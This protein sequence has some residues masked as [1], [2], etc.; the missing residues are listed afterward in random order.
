MTLI[1]LVIAVGAAITWQPAVDIATG[2]G[3]KG[4][5]QQNNSRFDY[6]DDP[7]VV[8]LPG[9]A[10]AVAWVDQRDKDIHLQ[11]FERTGAPRLPHAVNVSRTPAI[12]SWLPRLAIA[13]DHPRAIYVLWQEIVFS[14]G[15]HGGEIL[16]ARSLDGGA[17]FSAPLNLSRSQA[18]DGKARLST[19]AWHNGSLD[20]AVAPDRTLHAAW[21]DYEGALWFASSSD[22]G[23]SFTSPTQIAGTHDLPARAPSLAVDA[24]NT[25]YLAWTI[26]ETDHADVHVASRI[27]GGRFGAPTL[28]ATT[29]S[30]S[31]AP[32]LAIDRAGTL[33]LAFAESLGGRFDR[34]R[35]HYTRSFDHGRSFSAPVMLAGDGSGFPALATDGERVVV[36]WEVTGAND[37]RPRGLGLAFSRDLGDHFTTVPLVPQSRDRNGGFNGSQQGHLTSKLAVRDGQ[38]AI[39]NASLAAGRGSRVW[40]LRGQLPR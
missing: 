10:A 35:I 4:P 7:S 5:W 23:A 32:K 29:R 28:A 21:T 30:Y 8:L 26:G 11:I 3:T 9:G 37:D 19:D 31:D 25:I 16:F 39:G 15:S 17:T 20:L 12:F 6:V 1:A 33:H 34:T 40:L 27:R 14:G 36:L 22:G 24:D 18:G 13:S 38:V 2:G